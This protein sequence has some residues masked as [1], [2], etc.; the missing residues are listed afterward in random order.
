MKNL[1]RDRSHPEAHLASS[2]T[3]DAA[4]RFMDLTREQMYDIKVDPC[5]NCVLSVRQRL[6]PTEKEL[7]SL[8]LFVGRPVDQFSVEYYAV[9]H[10]MGVHF[11]A[12]E[13]GQSPRGGSVITCVID[14]QSL[15]ARVERFMTLEDDCPGYASVVWFDKPQYPSGTPLV[16]KVHDDGSA[17]E[18]THNNILR[19]TQIDPSRV[20]IESDSDPNVYYVMRDSGFDTMSS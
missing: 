6:Y 20:V 17:V 12:G 2:A 14:G 18:H 11:R 1:V 15:Y 8:S 16:V 4:A 13:W 9:A 19:I 7:E 5:H 3:Q 10:I